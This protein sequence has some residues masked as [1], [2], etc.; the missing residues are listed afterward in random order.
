[1][2]SGI[3]DSPASDARISKAVY[4]WRRKANGHV[5]GNSIATAHKLADNTIFA[6]RKPEMRVF[7][8]TRNDAKVVQHLQAL[9]VTAIEKAEK[10]LGTARVGIICHGFIPTGNRAIFVRLIVKV[11]TPVHSVLNIGEHI[12]PLQSI[13][14]RAS[15]AGNSAKLRPDLA[16]GRGDVPA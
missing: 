7:A 5:A 9:Q 6:S 14:T 1:M 16:K 12:A 11:Q 4:H 15:R 13:A 8:H 10:E 2:D 3:S